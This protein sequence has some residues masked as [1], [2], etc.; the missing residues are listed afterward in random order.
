MT[1][2][3]LTVVLIKIG[4]N[5]TM[6]TTVTTTLPPVTSTVTQTVTP[7]NTSTASSVQSFSLGELLGI[8]LLLFMI[9]LLAGIIIDAA[10]LVGKNKE[11]R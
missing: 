5:V 9:G 8:G 6:T 4:G 1:T 11:S 2:T 3:T 10:F 7:T